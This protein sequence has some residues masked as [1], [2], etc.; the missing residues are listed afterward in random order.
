MKVR[1]VD[2]INYFIIELKKKKIYMEEIFY[3]NFYVK[4]IL[5]LRIS[6]EK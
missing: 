6:L 4:I 2:Y 3:Y 1:G 5:G